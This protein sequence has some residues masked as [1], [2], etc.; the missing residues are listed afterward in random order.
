M[1]HAG[2]VR[3]GWVQFL[4]VS[5]ACAWFICAIV[6]PCT[7]PAIHTQSQGRIPSKSRFQKRAVVE[8][9]WSQK[10]TDALGMGMRAGLLST[11]H[12]QVG[13]GYTQKCAVEVHPLG[14]NAWC[15]SPSSVTSGVT[16][17]KS[18]KHLAK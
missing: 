6:L 2:V 10:Y 5:V 9:H 13:H 8:R 16:S 3:T 7:V 11:C 15:L 4:I 17:Q 14:M 1:V 18:F 12:V